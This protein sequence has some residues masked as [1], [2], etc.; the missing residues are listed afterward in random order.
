M[1]GDLKKAMLAKDN[2]QKNTIR[3][4]LSTVK[5]HEIDGGKQT[6]FEIARVLNKMIKQRI[7][8]AKLFQEQK[9]HDLMQ[10]E[11]QEAAAIRKY[12]LALPVASED[13]I[14]EKLK[15]FVAEIRKNQGDDTHI[16]KVFKEISD[17]LAQKWGASPNVVKA[18]VPGVYKQVF[19]K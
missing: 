9:R 18:M 14:E 12:I 11:E 17:D 1:K 15:D 8:S 4:V 19:Q 2:L 10:A 13:E 7:D 16:S 5:N 6:E 3:S